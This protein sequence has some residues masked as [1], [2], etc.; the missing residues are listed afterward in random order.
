MN[1]SRKKQQLFIILAAIFL[2]NAILAEMGLRRA[3]GDFSLR[4]AG[5][6]ENAHTVLRPPVLNAASFAAG[7][8]LNGPRRIKLQPFARALHLVEIGRFEPVHRKIPQRGKP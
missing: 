8:R 4:P 1:E 5:L 2:T 6:S 7:G 3:V